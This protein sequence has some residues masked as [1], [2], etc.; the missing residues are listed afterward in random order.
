MSYSELCIEER[1]TLQVS[2]AQGLSIRKV[3]TLL[4]RSPATISREIRRN[5]S[6]DGRYRAPDAQQ[7]RHDRRGGCRPKRKLIPGSPRFALIQYMLRRRLSPEQISGK[8]RDMNI[9]EL[10]DAYVCRETI[11][12]AIYALPVGEL[13]KEL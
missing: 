7:R 11:Y 1:A 12:S 6:P 5:G 4:E 13:R 9:P 3:A 10:R 2:L 8:L